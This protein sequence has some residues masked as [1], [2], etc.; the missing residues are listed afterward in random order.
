MSQSLGNLISNISCINIREDKCIDRTCHI[1]V[2]TFCAGNSRRNGCIKLNFTDDRKFRCHFLCFRCCLTH[3]IYI[4]TFTRSQ[5]RITQE[6][7]LRINTEYLG[8]FCTSYCNLSQFIFCRLDVDG[9]V[10]HCQ[11]CI[12]IGS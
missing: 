3:L 5:C 1:A 2:R 11:Y 12:S 4:F 9:T 10:S 7:N 6:T 8:T